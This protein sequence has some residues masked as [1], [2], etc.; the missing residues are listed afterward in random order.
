MILLYIP[1]DGDLYK[2]ETNEIKTIDIYIN[3]FCFNSL[4]AQE[5]G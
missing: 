2:R 5:Y 3:Y 1:I 4:G